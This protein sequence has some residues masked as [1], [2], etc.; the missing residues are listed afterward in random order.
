MVVVLIL[1]EEAV[2][3]QQLRLIMKKSKRGLLEKKDI[4]KDMKMGIKEI[5]VHQIIVEIIVIH[6]N[7]STQKD[8]KR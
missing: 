3:E 7:Q 8:M 2:L 5:I 1:E 4:I 6:M